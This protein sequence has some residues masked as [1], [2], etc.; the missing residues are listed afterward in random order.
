[1]CFNMW[2]PH[3][4]CDIKHSQV[5]WKRETLLKTSEGENPT[6]VTSSGSC[7]QEPFVTVNPEGHIS[8]WISVTFCPNTR[9]SGLPWVLN[10]RSRSPSENKD[11]PSL[12][13]RVIVLSPPF[14][15]VVT[16]MFVHKNRRG[17]WECNR[18]WWHAGGDYVTAQTV[19]HVT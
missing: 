7:S 13:L 15:S 12:T 10:D 3:N 9:T 17:L 19:Q 2:L 11:S 6:E 8:K 16:W 5:T 1:M 4:L 14:L 18:L